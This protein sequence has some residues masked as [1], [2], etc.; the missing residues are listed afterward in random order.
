MNAEIES[1]LQKAEKTSFFET[2]LSLN[3][4]KEFLNYLISFVLVNPRFSWIDIL[5]LML[6]FRDSMADKSEQTKI[7]SMYRRK[8][9]WNVLLQNNRLVDIGT[10]DE[11]GSVLEF[12]DPAI[13]YDPPIISCRLVQAGAYMDW[14]LGG[15]ECRLYD[16][17]S[18]KNRKS[19]AQ[20]VMQH[21]VSPIWKAVYNLFG[22]SAEDIKE[23][24]DIFVRRY[25]VPKESD[26]WIDF[27]AKEVVQGVVSLDVRN[28][29]E[30]FLA[31]V[32]KAAILMGLNITPSETEKEKELNYIPQPDVINDGSMFI[33]IV[34]LIH[35][36]PYILTKIYT[37]QWEKELEHVHKDGKDDFMTMTLKERL[38]EARYIQQNHLPATIT[39]Q[40]RKDRNTGYIEI[41]GPAEMMSEMVSGKY[42]SNERTFHPGGYEI[43]RVVLRKASLESAKYIFDDQAVEI[44]KQMNVK[45]EEGLENRLVQLYTGLYKNKEE[46]ELKLAVIHDVASK[47]TQLGADFDF[48]EL[49]TNADP[50]IWEKSEV[51]Q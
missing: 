8:D 23:W 18:I 30:D 31:S 22:D 34:N 17:V 49:V 6:R 33:L 7:Y 11:N 15:E 51:K 39:L 21:I 48:V 5:A 26:N 12:D 46:N 44:M 20:S 43:D 19:G 24:S 37:D 14:D 3:S 2:L 38:A 25:G 45:S 10:P 9:D 16:L 47:I 28:A 40:R 41:L 29:H 35:F 27:L 36:I 4:N 50:P 1:L 32:V 42:A 13:T